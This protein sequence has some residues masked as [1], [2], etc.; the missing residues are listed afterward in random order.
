MIV[1]IINDTHF[2][3]RSD[4]LFFLEYQ[5]M[6]YRD[7]FFPTLKKHSV[8]KVYHLGDLFDRRKYININTLFETKAMFLEPLR[9]YPTIMI[10]GNHDC[11]WSNKNEVNSLAGL[12]REYDNIEILEEPSIRDEFLFVP[13][14]NNANYES[15]LKAIKDTDA[16]RV[17]GH[18]DIAGFEMYRN[19]RSE[20]GMTSDIFSRFDSVWS[21]H[22]HHK[23]NI[24]N[25]HYLGSPMQFTWSDYDDP[26]GFHIYDTETNI[27]TYIEN[28]YTMFEKIY[29]DDSSNSIDYKSFD[30]ES[31]KNKIVKIFVVKKT[32]PALYDYFIDKMLKAECLDISIH[33]NYEV[34]AENTDSND[35]Y[36]SYSTNELIEIYVNSIQSDHDKPKIK[37]LINELYIESL[38]DG[39]N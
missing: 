18:F 38:H 2:G 25:I 34:L 21:G 39:R 13:W 7:I 22:F 3:I 11:Y 28:P 19:N 37:K 8:E 23:S 33:E 26:R 9:E 35:E 14:I 20:H 16:K 36:I 27:L 32:S 31:Y 30:F 5:K 24:G 1:A 4:S 15:T 29:Y 6:F 12:L 10:P 17:C